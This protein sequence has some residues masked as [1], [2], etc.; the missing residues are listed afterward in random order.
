MV[1]LC[2]LKKENG[3]QQQKESLKRWPSHPINA[4]PFEEQLKMQDYVGRCHI[5]QSDGYQTFSA[6]GA[7]KVPSLQLWM[8]KGTDCDPIEPW[9]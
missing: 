3:T 6:W 7:L 5:D 2:F 9:P 8:I 1:R 4:P